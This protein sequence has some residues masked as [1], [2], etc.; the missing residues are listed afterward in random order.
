VGWTG[1][2]KVPPPTQTAEVLAQQ[3]D[4]LR[5]EHD[6]L[7]ARIADVAAVLAGLALE[8][9]AMRGVPAERARSATLRRRL[10]E[11]EA[12]LGRCKAKR[13][14]NEVAQ[15]H[16]T[17]LAAQVAAGNLGDP[18][19]HLQRP[20]LPSSPADVRLGR[21]AAIWSAISV[22][23][24]LLGVAALTLFSTDLAPGIA[25]LLGTYGFFEALF[26]RDVQLWIVRLVVGLAVVTTLVLLLQF[27]QPIMLGIVALVGIFIIVDNVREVLT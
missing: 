24:L 3:Q 8:A 18:R 14:A 10:D 1:L 15:E 16:C 26:H 12:E 23:V 22:G 17:A 11:T 25:A 4:R 20:A 2:D 19:S 27:F 9:T 6:E 21:L 5:L 7:T 13:A